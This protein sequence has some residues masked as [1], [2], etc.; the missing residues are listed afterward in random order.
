L[1][2][3]FS[4]AVARSED[5]A[6]LVIFAASALAVAAIGEGL[7][8]ARDRADRE[9]RSRDEVLRIVAHDLRSPLAAVRLSIAGAQ[10]SMP[11]GAA[12]PR[13]DVAERALE[14]IDRLIADLVDAAKLDAGPLAIEPS[15]LDFASLMNDVVE[16]CRESFAEKE[17]DLKMD[18]GPVG[19][20]AIDRDR[21]MQAV[22]N[23]L[24]NALQHTPRGGSVRVTASRDAE[25]LRVT[26]SDT[27]AG[28]EA[29]DLEHVFNRFWTK[30]G[31]GTGLGLFISQAIVHAHGGRISVKSRPGVGTTFEIVIPAT[32]RPES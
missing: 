9:R 19:R 1:K 26:V 27:G 2:P 14:R 10:R 16:L 7:H 4:F 13:L 22:T 12:I 31:V 23:I 32:P 5:I 18:I 25:M 15:D 11:P 24:T 17:I 8:R 28:I 30:R 29:A 21:W 6:G 3:Y 20:A